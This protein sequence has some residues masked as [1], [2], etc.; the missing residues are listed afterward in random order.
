MAKMKPRLLSICNVVMVLFGYFFVGVMSGKE[1]VEMTS[2]QPGIIGSSITFKVTLKNPVEESYDVA[3]TEQIWGQKNQRDSKGVLDKGNG[4]TANW[5]LTYSSQFAPG[6]YP[7]IATISYPYFIFVKTLGTFVT[8]FN[9]SKDFSGSLIVSQPSAPVKKD[10]TFVSTLNETELSVQLHDPYKFLAKADNVTWSWYNE[11]GF[12]ANTTTPSKKFN[13]TKEGEYFVN[14]TLTALYNTSSPNDT[15][16]IGGN[17]FTNI[18]AK[19][20]EKYTN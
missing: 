1:S 11:S 19:G 8:Y 15:K 10:P 17:F 6:T 9:L 12:I 18:T 14:V 13:F 2:D 3:W 20:K 5:T 7:V 16:V 4:F